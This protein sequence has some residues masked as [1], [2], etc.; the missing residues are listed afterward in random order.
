[1][2]SGLVSVIV[3]NW[4]GA[5]LLPACLDAIEAQDYPLVE[6]IVVDNGSRD[7]SAEM[8]ASRAS[9]RLIRNRANLGFAVANN[10]AIELATG[11]FVLLLNYDAVLEPGYISALVGALRAD[12][13]R[14]SVSGKLLRPGADVPRTIDSTGHI[15]YR[16]VWAANRGQ[17]EPDQPRYDVAGEVFGVCAAAG[18]YRRAMLEDVRVDGEV[19]DASFF[20]YLEDV[21]LDWR[22]RL[23]GWRSWYE[24]TAVATH[25]RSASGGRF[26]VP[27]QRHIFKNR[28]LMIVK[29]DGGASLVWRLPGIVAFTAVKLMIGIVRGPAFGTAVV[30]VIRILPLAWR[31]RRLIQ[32]RRRVPQSALDPWFFPYPY[33]TKLRG[34]RFSRLPRQWISQS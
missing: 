29:N 1:M 17:D 10:I 23:R 4:N 22:A 11:E 30:D 12:E 19:L 3:V 24:P 2:I 33:I 14:G 34:R 20:S 16:N 13:S 5:H 32:A 28:V 7:G 9:I 18:M 27:I 31:K 15:M 21:D 8:A 25:H 26:L 6:V